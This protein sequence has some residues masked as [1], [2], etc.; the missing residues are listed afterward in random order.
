MS[1]ALLM[2]SLELGLIYG[3]IAIA[4]YLSF[5]VIDFCDLSADGSL[6]T[7]ACVCA[8]TLKTGASPFT[9]L[10]IATLSGG[11]CG[12]IPA[13]L[14]QQLKI[15]ELLAG[16]LTAFILYSINLKITGGLPNIALLDEP[17]IFENTPASLLL[18]A[19]YLLI[20]LAIAYSLITRWGLR[21]RSLGLNPTLAKNYGVR[22]APQVWVTLG[23]SHALIGLSGGLLCQLQGFADVSMGIGT[24]I[25]GLVAIVLT[26]KL[27]RSTNMAVTVLCLAIG[28]VAF[29]L[30]LALALDG[31]RWGVQASD[32][33]L[34]T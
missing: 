2:T 16:I 32:L 17:S 11:V 6:A 18:A 5:R 25:L 33:N 3:L 19:I 21:L 27:L 20:A 31:D 24:V 34:I 9:S 26:E 4:I 13:M 8:V 10:L 28:S 23:L 15:S 14:N 1:P 29:R 12:M 7:G 30:I 22:K